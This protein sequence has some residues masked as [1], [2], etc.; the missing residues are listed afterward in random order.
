MVCMEGGQIKAYVSFLVLLC[1]F[2]LAKHTYCIH[3][4][5]SCALFFSIFSYLMLILVLL[6]S[7]FILLYFIFPL[8]MKRIDGIVHSDTKNNTAVSH[9]YMHKLSDSNRLCSILCGR[10][11]NNQTTD[12]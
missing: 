3:I 1:L 12:I 8:E 9:L 2:L 10:K 5:F 6:S 4:C 11:V 7:H